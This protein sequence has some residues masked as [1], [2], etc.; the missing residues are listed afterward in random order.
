MI[1]KNRMQ[2]HTG[3]LNSNDELWNVL[4]LNTLQK[5]NVGCIVV[6]ALAMQ[7]H[8]YFR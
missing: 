6:Q 8:I 3:I 5:I 7:M 2:P 4:L 1:I